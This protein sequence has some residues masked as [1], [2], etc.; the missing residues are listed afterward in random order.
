M[1]QDGP[2]LITDP[3]PIDILRYRYHH[4][5]N[6]GSVFVLERWLQPSRFPDGSS[7]SS[8]LAAVQAHVQKY[9][10]AEARAK[11][12]EAW[13]KAV[14]DA[15][16][17]W[18]VNE[19]KV[20]AI[21]LP[22]GFFD[23]DPSFCQDTPFAPFAAVYTNAWS[24]I[25]YLVCRLR[26]NGIGTLLDLHALP[27]GANE[28]EHS[29]TNCGK[30]T[31]FTDQKNRQLG[32]RAVRFLAEKIQNGLDG[33]VGIQVVNEAAWESERMYE[34]YDDCVEAVSAIDPTIPVVISDAWNLRKAVDYSLAKNVA[35]PKGPTAP[36]VIDTHYYWCFSDDHKR[37]S[38]QEVIVDVNS[39]LTQ[40]DGKEG[41]VMDRGAV[42]AIVGE[43]SCVLSE[44]AWA[45]CGNA[46]R[47]DLTR[48]FGEAQSRRYQ[49]R[50]GGAFFWTW[51]MDWMPGGGWGF[52][53]QTSK[54]SILPPYTSTVDPSTFPSLIAKANN[55][56]DQRMWHAVD[57]HVQYWDHLA[58]NMG[59]E[60][61]RYENGWKVGFYDALHFLEG[62]VSNN[63]LPGNRIANLELWVMK[64]IRESGFQGKFVWEFEQG[65]RRGIKD[66]EGI[67]GI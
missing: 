48:Q 37:K 64:R 53:S 12:E 60:H 39:K 13:S 35:Y 21:R 40:L 18:L 44:E 65:L 24:H 38:P 31:L 66:F 41:S 59:G 36:V 28:Q 10:I 43:Y 54:S 46:S 29:G 62:S 22:I 1:S 23:L 58:P 20:T 6:L 33:V 25:S 8:E 14:S 42:Q 19:A 67:V 26:A 11:F 5:V 52:V 30:A 27:G 7:G 61:W 34:W 2:N 32:V 17:A 56:R 63:I 49:D 45:K 47:D 50:S 51:K 55:R 3:S 57:Q 15:D 4:G 9:G 16:I